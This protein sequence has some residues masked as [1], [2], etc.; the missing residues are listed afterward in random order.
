M[1]FRDFIS[2][3]EGSFSWDFAEKAVSK[4][5]NENEC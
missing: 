4:T 2:V 1:G 3:L 5:C